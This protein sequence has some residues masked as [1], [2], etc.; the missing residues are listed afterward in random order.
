M[1][2]RSKHDFYFVSIRDPL[3]RLISAF[4]YLHPKNIL[5]RKE[6]SNGIPLAPNKAAYKCFPTLEKFAN[7]VGTSGGYCN[8][9]AKRAVGGRVKI[10]SHLYSN[11]HKM[12]API[13]A[14]AQ[15]YVFRNE[16]IWEDWEAVNKLLDPNRT[17]VIPTGKKVRDVTN[18]KQPVSRDLSS[19][20]RD[21]LCRAIQQEYEVFFSLLKRAVNLNETD[22]QD[23]RD[24]ANKNCPNLVAPRVSL[25][26]SKKKSKGSIANRSSTP[27]LLS[28]RVERPTESSPI[29]VARS[30]T[31]FLALTHNY[32][33][34]A[35]FIHVGK[36]GGSSLTSQLRNGC[37]SFVKKPCSVIANETAISELV[38]DY[39]HSESLV[40]NSKSNDSFRTFH[41]CTHRFV[42]F[43]SS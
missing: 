28:D 35:G 2:P 13:P 4:A 17:V 36:C 15:V 19:R 24:T 23:A 1:I 38:T 11:Y 25:I 9:H 29:Q 22:I 12:V 37:H 8:S 3:E 27:G 10:M 16:H 34:T 40:S 31:S 42:H 26:G 18:V 21:Y 33:K 6:R 14:D 20:G 7:D 5:A 39:Y 32:T 30:E 41:C 43:L